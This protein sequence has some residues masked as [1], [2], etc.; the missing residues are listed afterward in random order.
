MYRAIIFVLFLFILTGCAREVITCPPQLPPPVIY[1]QEIPEP[2]FKGAANKDL[3]DYII[4]LRTALK[5]ANADKEA[6][7]EYYTD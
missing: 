7:R 2:I 3:L 5:T 6:I 1:L 4:D